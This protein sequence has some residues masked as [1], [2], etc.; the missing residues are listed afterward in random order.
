M[1]DIAQSSAENKIS[2]ENFRLAGLNA[3]IAANKL[4]TVTSGVICKSLEQ[5]DVFEKK[6]S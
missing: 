6:A 3:L 5:H 2:N 1:S 4:E